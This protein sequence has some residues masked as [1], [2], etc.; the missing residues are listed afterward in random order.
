MFPRVAV[1]ISVATR[2]GLRNWGI[3]FTINTPF[4]NAQ[5]LIP[6]VSLRKFPLCCVVAQTLR[7]SIVKRRHRMYCSA[8]TKENNAK[9]RHSVLQ[10]RR[11]NFLLPNCVVLCNTCA[12]EERHPN[13][14]VTPA[15][16][17]L[18]QLTPPLSC[19]S[20]FV[21]LYRRKA[22]RKTKQNKNVR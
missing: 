5:V 11:R 17:I 10:F 12:Y 19:V 6:V 3:G 4:S 18:H 14:D 7:R 20:F 13:Y 22:K 8:T 16:Y 15:Q 2:R 21:M 1:S 9:L